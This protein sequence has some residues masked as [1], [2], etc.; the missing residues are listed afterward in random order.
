MECSAFCFYDD[1]RYSHGHGSPTTTH[2]FVVGPVGIAKFVRDNSV[3]T[4]LHLRFALEVVELEHNVAS[5]VQLPSF[6]ADSPFEITACPLR[7]RV[8]CFGN[9]L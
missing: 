5:R 9:L 6:A 8:P 7:H 4:D 2:M 3:A 1:R